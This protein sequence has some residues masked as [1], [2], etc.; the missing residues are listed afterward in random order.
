MAEFKKPEWS[1]Y[2]LASNTKLHGL[3]L[4]ELRF[5]FSVLSPPEKNGAM[6]WK[7]GMTE[8]A[9]ASSTLDLDTPFI[10]PGKLETPKPSHASPDGSSRGIASSAKLRKPNEPPL[11]AKP[12]TSTV[13]VSKLKQP[14]RARPRPVAQVS[15][16]F[17]KTEIDFDPDASERTRIY[18]QPITSSQKRTPAPLKIEIVRGTKSVS[19]HIVAMS[20]SKLILNSPIPP[21]MVGPVKVKIHCALGEFP[22]QAEVLDVSKVKLVAGRELEKFSN[23]I[24]LYFS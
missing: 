1:L 21:E 11:K 10:A 5:A 18:K 2:V 7:P 23:W 9:N 22:Y 17:D 19:K 15:Q 24:T 16:D 3:S 20:G 6:L 13:K 4:D 8:W 14:V 12:K